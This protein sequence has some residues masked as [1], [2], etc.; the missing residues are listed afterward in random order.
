MI[1]FLASDAAGVGVDE[2]EATTDLGLG[3]GGGGMTPF[4]GPYSRIGRFS[5]G[6]FGGGGLGSLTANIVAS[7]TCGSTV[8]VT[9]PSLT[10]LSL[11]GLLGS[12][13]T[14]PLFFIGFVQYFSNICSVIHWLRDRTKDSW[15]TPLRSGHVRF[16][17]S[18]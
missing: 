2:V 15:R 5:V 7:K 4:G 13:M 3:V 17:Q 18:A 1:G 16:S 11:G 6:G 8:I 10:M 9:W 12:S 14:A